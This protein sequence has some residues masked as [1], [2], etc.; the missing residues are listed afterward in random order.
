[1]KAIVAMDQNRGIGFKGAIPWYLPEDLQWF[2]QFTMGKTLVMGRTTFL[3]LPRLKGR[4]ICVLTSVEN[5]L[6]FHLR[7][8]AKCEHLYIRKPQA[9]SAWGFNPSDWPDAIVCGGAKTYKLL[10]PFCTDVYV[11]HVLDEY[12][13]DTYMPPFED[14]FPNQEIIREAKDYWIVRY[15]L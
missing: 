6:D 4:S 3:G 7:Y 14:Q 5:Q 10:L 1:M 2:K 12:D 15:S 13:S 9:T 11:T 8:A